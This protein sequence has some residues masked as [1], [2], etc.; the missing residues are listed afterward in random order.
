[1]AMAADG[2]FQSQLTK[3]AA[4]DAQLLSNSIGSLPPGLKQLAREVIGLGAPIS[5]TSRELEAI[6]GGRFGAAIQ[7]FQRDLDP[8]AF[9]NAMKT[10]SADVMRNAEAFGEASLAGGGFGETLNSVVSMIGEAISPD[11]LEK[12]TKA[13]GDNIENLVN[14]SSELDRL[15]AAVETTRFQFLNPFL[16]SGQTAVNTTRMLNE[17]MD[18]LSKEGMVAF[19]Q[20][21]MSLLATLGVDV[22]TLK[23]SGYNPDAGTK[24]RSF[25][26]FGFGQGDFDFSSTEM[27]LEAFNYGSDGFQNFG[28]GRPAM[29]HGVE[30]VVTPS[31]MSKLTKEVMAMASKTGTEA[32]AGTTATNNGNQVMSQ[33][34]DS[35]ERIAQHLNTLITIGTMTEKNTKD[36]KN[37]L[38][39]MGG[40]LV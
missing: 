5:E 14:L 27:P 19:Q 40:S 10:I 34:A 18:Q 23:A 31:Q 9:T 7:A 35:N 38:A 20:G 1:L 24:K 39:N 11:M 17:K 33:L 25:N 2:V 22:E 4:G 15:K 16:Y 12:E 21:M 36:T 3:M 28:K 29:L 6:S 26:I 30:A 32:P 37:N 8:L 13:R